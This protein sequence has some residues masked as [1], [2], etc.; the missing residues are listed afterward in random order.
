MTKRSQ[1]KND[2]PDWVD[3]SS[4]RKTPYS[5]EELERFV[6]DFIADMA[7]VPAWSGL[8]RDLGEK[9]ARAILKKGFQAQDERNLAN[10]DPDGPA[11]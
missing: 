4:D 1:S 9:R 10:W 3:P 5:D 7:D 8:V 6:T 2:E 11:N